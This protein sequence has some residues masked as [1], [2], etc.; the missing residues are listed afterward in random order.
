MKKHNQKTC[1]CKAYPFP[2]RLDGGKCR[3]FYNNNYYEKD[4]IFNLGLV[5][6]FKLDNSQPLRNP[7]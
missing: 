4:T 3:E 6:L 2:H 7:L 5:S 1:R